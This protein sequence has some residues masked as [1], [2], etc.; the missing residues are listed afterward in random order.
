[1]TAMSEEFI[2]RPTPHLERD[3]EMSVFGHAGLPVLLFPTSTGRCQQAKACGLIDSVAPL[4]EAGRIKVY[5]PDGIDEESWSN[6]L[7]PPAERVQVHL[8]WE[9][10]I[11]DL[12]DAVRAETGAPRVV[13]AGCSF[14]GYHA[15]N[16]AFRH[17]DRVAAMISMSGAFDIRQLLHGYFDQDCYFL[18]PVDYLPGLDDPQFL[19]PIRRMGIVL[20][21][22]EWDICREANQRLSGI[23]T[24][25]GIAHWLDVRPG[26]VHDWP[27]WRETFPLYIS[28]IVRH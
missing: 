20:S 11:L 17:P 4:L 1:M 13:V 3:L 23:L 8:K 26:A 6:Y 27:L 7:I 19:E 14:G 5:C 25:K 21:T 22:G 12:I 15:A 28:Q 9:R 10:A 18:N 2:R 16:L 24:Q